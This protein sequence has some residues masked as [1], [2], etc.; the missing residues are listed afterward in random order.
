MDFAKFVNENGL[1]LRKGGGMYTSF[2]CYK[3]EKIC[4]LDLYSIRRY[5]PDGTWDIRPNNLLFDDYDKYVTDDKLKEFILKSLNFILCP[6]C[7]GG[8]CIGRDENITIFGKSFSYVCSGSPLLIMNP[9][10]EALERAKELVL[11]TKNIIDDNKLA[12]QA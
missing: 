2:V 6:R 5:K 3:K 1:T 4:A 9:Q 11:I 10:N 12:S 8:Q 7:N